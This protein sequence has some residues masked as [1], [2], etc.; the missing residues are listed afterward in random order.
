MFVVVVM[1]GVLL[2]ILIFTWSIVCYYR[3]RNAK[4]KTLKP[5]GKHD[6]CNSVCRVL[7]DQGCVSA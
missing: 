2:A 1:V 7:M 3:R 5:I 4:V 6:V